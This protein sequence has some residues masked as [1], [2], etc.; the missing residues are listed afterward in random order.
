MQDTYD[1][2][3]AMTIAA[4]IE[5]ALDVPGPAEQANNPKRPGVKKTLH[6]HTMLAMVLITPTNTNDKLCK[7]H[8]R[9]C[10]AHSQNPPNS[11]NGKS[12]TRQSLGGRGVNATTTQRRRVKRHPPWKGRR[13]SFQGRIPR[14]NA[15]NLVSRCAERIT[16]SPG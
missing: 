5:L 14:L 7:A 10:K 1:E 9:L 13:S 2:D 15:R 8:S 4:D 16:G 12:A 6:L 3:D 11:L